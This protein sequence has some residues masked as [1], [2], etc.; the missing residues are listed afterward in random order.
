MLLVNDCTLQRLQRAATRSK[1]MTNPVFPKLANTLIKTLLIRPAQGITNKGYNGTLLHCLV[2]ATL[3]TW[4]WFLGLDTTQTQPFHE[5]TRYYS[6]SS[7]GCLHVNTK[8][9]A[10]L[11]FQDVCS[12]CC[13]TI[14]VQILSPHPFVYFR[15]LLVSLFF[16]PQ[17]KYGCLATNN[18]KE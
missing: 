16:A 9:Y 3:H 5:S 7:F 11:Y 14:S 1:C 6:F 2:I 15:L 8:D 17:I 13:I 10:H 4:K 18:N 12:S